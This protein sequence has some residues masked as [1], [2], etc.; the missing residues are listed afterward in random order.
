M[1]LSK[2]GMLF[3][4]C[5][6][7]AGAPAQEKILHLS[8]DAADKPLAHGNFQLENSPN[9]PRWSADGA[10]GGC[11]EFNGKDEFLTVKYTPELDFAED[12]SFTV[13]FF[14]KPD[15]VEDK[16]EHSYVLG[17]GNYGGGYWRLTKCQ[18]Y[19]GT[20]WLMATHLAEPEKNKQHKV[21]SKDRSEHWF[22]AAVVRDAKL[23]RWMFYLDGKPVKDEP[24]AN[25]NVFV[26][27]NEPLFIGGRPHHCPK[28]YKFFKGKIDEIIIWRGVVNDFSD[29]KVKV[30]VKEPPIAIDPAVARNW[31]LLNEQKLDLFPCPKRLELAGE[32][33]FFAPAEWKVTRKQTSDA[34]GL[35]AFNDRLN[36]LKMPALTGGGAKHEIVAGLYDELKDELAAAKAPAKPIR[37]GYVIVFR[38]T[39]EHRRVLLAGTDEDGLR[40]AWLALSELLKSDQT[41]QAANIADWP[42][43]E[44]RMAYT[45]RNGTTAELKPVIEEAFRART[46][47]IEMNWFNLES[48]QRRSVADWR[49]LN[50]YAA[51]RGIR[52]YPYMFPVLI[53]A[54]ND[55]RNWSKEGLF[56]HGGDSPYYKNGWFGWSRDDL[57]KARAAKI[58]DYLSEAG[59]R[60]LIIHGLDTGGVENPS[61]WN[62]RT[63]M[64]K[65][66]WGDDYAAALANLVGI[67]A[68]A[69]HRKIPDFKLQFIQ[70]PYIATKDEK[71]LNFYRRVSQLL[72]NRVSAY[73]LREA[74]RRLMAETV[75]C[76]PPE[77]P[78]WTAY[79]PFD[80]RIYPSY[81][82]SGR[83]AATFYF[84]EKSG[85]STMTASIGRLGNA[86]KWSAAEYQWNAFAPGAEYL[87]GDNDNRTRWA[88]DNSDYEELSSVSPVMEQELLPRL[89]R[90]LYGGKGADRMVA[91]YL[92]K[93][94]D[95][96]P[97]A[98][99]FAPG[100]QESFFSNMA[101]KSKK[102]RLELAQTRAEV[103]ARAVAPLDDTLRFL[104]E[105]E[106]LAEARLCC[107]QARRLLS[108]GKNDEAKAVAARGVKLLDNPVAKWRELHKNILNDLA[109]TDDIHRRVERGDYLKQ[110]QAKPVRVAFYSCSGTGGVANFIGRLPDS[111]NQAAGID[112]GI[113]SDL[114]AHRLSRIDVLVINAT[115]DMGDCSESWTENVRNFVANGGGIIFA[116][117]AVGRY[118][119]AFQPPLFPEICAGFAGLGLNRN[120]TVKDASCFEKFLNAGDRYETFYSDYCRLKAGPKGNVVLLDSE[121]QPA[122]VTGQYGKGKVVYTGEIFGYSP[123][124][125]GGGKLVDPPLAN[126]Q[127]LFNL[128]RWAAPAKP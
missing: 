12:Q 22:H 2:I 21:W 5:A 107:I 93:L 48:W 80:F 116:H 6:F 92:V 112:A 82:N 57:A 35:S 72:G 64:D 79:Y 117:N 54:G 44:T 14:C 45:I 28:P 41:M 102:L 97:G 124:G 29:R 122:M 32:P 25:P 84:G 24:E 127:M 60:A 125:P 10:R 89:C 27:P 37:Q 47:G 85:I 101:E 70:Y 78:P 56:S 31:A 52:I 30:A 13:E 94:T 66:R 40:Y 50:R 128:I 104:Q 91:V 96:L 36:D 1:S 9:P 17:K 63:A 120:L 105:C 83:H 69:V 4:C 110:I 111:L 7:A 119:S 95:R 74:P 88:Y 33:F 115:R 68:D 126:W 99:E 51:E 86:Q 76:F 71:T 81:T 18:N 34:A 55:G 109:V 118:Q 43:F 106:L 58:A 61:K 108:D 121:N 59:F 39:P 123:D 65:E 11:L 19:D 87:G 53:Q 8:F 3:A 38:G 46:N 103:F 73:C 42:D 98:P 23:K 67:F 62:D 20:L 49:E 26:S 15:A 77:T 100:N 16:T 113:V 75:K 90:L 114:T